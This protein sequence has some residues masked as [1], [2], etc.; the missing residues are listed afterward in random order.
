MK[1]GR[2]SGRCRQR[3]IPVIVSHSTAWRRHPDVTYFSVPQQTSMLQKTLLLHAPRRLAAYPQPKSE[4]HGPCRGWRSRGRN[5]AHRS[6]LESVP[7]FCCPN[8]SSAELPLPLHSG[9]CLLPSLLL[10]VCACLYVCAH[11]CACM[12]VPVCACMCFMTTTQQQS[13]LG[14]LVLVIFTDLGG[15]VFCL[16]S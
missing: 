16:K 2:G 6:Q 1:V 5:K 4:Q 3:R 8:P 11:V 7:P 10:C 15:L 12:C 9:W 13:S 14:L